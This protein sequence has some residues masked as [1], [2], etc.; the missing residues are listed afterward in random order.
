MVYGEPLYRFSALTLEKSNLVPGEVREH[1]QF[2]VYPQGA[3]RI[4]SG[5]EAPTA[6][7]LPQWRRGPSVAR[8]PDFA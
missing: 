8:V 7:L 3:R 5:A 1:R 4:R 2:G 6:P